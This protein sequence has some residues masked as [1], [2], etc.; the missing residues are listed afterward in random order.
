MAAKRACGK[1]GWPPTVVCMIAFQSNMTSALAAA[2]INAT[3]IT[4]QYVFQNRILLNVLTVYLSVKF[5]AR[6]L[7]DFPA[8]RSRLKSAETLALEGQAG[9]NYQTCNLPQKLLC[10]L[11]AKRLEGLP[12]IAMNQG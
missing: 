4:L 10:A 12:R 11:T 3:A 5:R 1:G 6:G 7:P 2:G 9:N 8:I